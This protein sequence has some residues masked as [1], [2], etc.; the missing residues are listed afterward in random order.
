MNV[1]ELFNSILCGKV[2][3][4]HWGFQLS[5]SVFSVSIGQTNIWTRACVRKTYLLNTKYIEWHYKS[6]CNRNRN[7]F[8]IYWMVFGLSF[9]F[10][11]SL[12][13]IRSIWFDCNLGMLS[14]MHLS[15][16]CAW[17]GWH[18]VCLWINQLKSICYYT[19]T[20]LSIKKT[21]L[22]LPPCQIFFFL[23]KVE[24]LTK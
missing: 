23:K 22:P 17:C 7:V 1:V 12:S 16:V 2:G 6:S 20:Y 21:T 24:I 11:V 3:I 19:H 14:Q 18:R 15:C 5:L 10:I 8:T 9:Y 4:S 13:L